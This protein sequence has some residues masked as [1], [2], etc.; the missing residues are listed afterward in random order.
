[1]FKLK[2]RQVEFADSHGETLTGTHV[3]V[4]QMTI[5]AGDILFRKM[6]FGAPP[7]GVEK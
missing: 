6:D 4:T 5:K 7:N 3:L 2:N 1:I